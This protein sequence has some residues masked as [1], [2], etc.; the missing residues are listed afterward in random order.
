M[1][2]HDGAEC[3]ELVGLYILHRLATD[4]TEGTN[5]SKFR[6]VN[7]GFIGMMSL[8]YTEEKPKLGWKE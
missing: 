8:M 2:A 1:G 3:T 5:E 6:D 4:K 7:F